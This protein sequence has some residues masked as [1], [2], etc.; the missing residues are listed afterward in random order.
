MHNC[1][2]CV[3]QAEPYSNQTQNM[4]S[5]VHIPKHSMRM[6]STIQQDLEGMPEHRSRVAVGYNTALKISQ[7][8]ACFHA[9]Y[10]GM[11]SVSSGSC[12]KQTVK[13]RSPREK[14]RASQPVDYPWAGTVSSHHIE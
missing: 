6:P 5:E 7:D 13:A 11:H 3:S 4:G 9:I 12:L 10:N 8:C 14:S 1:S 2:S